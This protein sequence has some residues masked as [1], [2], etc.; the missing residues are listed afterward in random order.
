MEQLQKRLAQQIG[1]IMEIDKLKHIYRQNLVADRSGKRTEIPGTWRH[2][3][4]AAGDLPGP[5]MLKV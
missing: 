5:W 3:S 1:F 2:G 4:A